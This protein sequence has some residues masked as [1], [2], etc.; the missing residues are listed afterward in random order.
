LLQGVIL[1]AWIAIQ[2]SIIG[3]GSILQPIYFALGLAIAGLCL[4]PSVRA[5][6]TLT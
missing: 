6:Y 3:Y 5:Y 1:M 4:L 2:V